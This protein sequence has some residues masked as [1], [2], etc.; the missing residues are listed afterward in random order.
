MEK[1][2]KNISKSLENKIKGKCFKYFLSLS[3][4][5]SIVESGKGSTDTEDGDHPEGKVGEDDAEQ[6]EA[7]GGEGPPVDLHTAAPVTVGLLDQLPPGQVALPDLHQDEDVEEAGEEERQDGPQQGH[8][9][10]HPTL[11]PLPGEPPGVSQEGG[12]DPDSQAAGQEN[13]EGGRA[14]PR[15]PAGRYSRALIGP[16]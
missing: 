9:H 4:P 6:N 11:H 10:H 3:S 5:E 12:Q 2:I 7:D 8:P 14:G 1:I 13:T 16:H 15:H